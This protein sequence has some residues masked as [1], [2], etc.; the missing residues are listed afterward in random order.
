[1]TL[2]RAPLLP[3]FVV[4]LLIASLLVA[5]DA[6]VEEDEDDDRDDDGT[7]DIEQ[8]DFRTQQSGNIHDDFS[9]V[10]GEVPDFGG[11]FFDSDGDLNVYVED[12]DPDR[13]PDVRSVL[14]DVFG[15]DLFERADSERNPTGDAEVVLL[16]GTY[17]FEALQ[18]WFEEIHDVFAVDE[19]VFIDLDER[20]N[21]LV[22]AAEQEAAFEEI[23]AELA[24]L[25]VP[26]E[27]INLKQTTPIDIQNQDLRDQFEI[28]SQ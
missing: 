18:G 13:I 5:C 10:S 14:E 17:P 1:M 16:E 4:I 26:R 22:I 25:E 28:K 24:E 20:E 2:F 11:L 3:T 21:R 15:A 6:L 19:V 12:T 7:V 23:E 8:I 27:A 9:R